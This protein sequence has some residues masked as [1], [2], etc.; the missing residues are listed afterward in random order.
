LL[1]IYLIRR[2]AEL[3][4]DLNGKRS[5]FEVITFSARK[6][7]G[8]GVPAFIRLDEYDTPTDPDM[9]AVKELLRREYPEYFGSSSSE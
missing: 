9:S 7:L 4:V 6:G 1:P 8:P 5:G 3:L 2:D